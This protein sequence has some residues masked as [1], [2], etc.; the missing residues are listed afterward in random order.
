MTAGLKWAARASDATQMK[1]SVLTHFGGAA[2]ALVLCTVLAGCGKA[3]PRR[4][5]AGS[6]VPVSERDF[7][8]AS[9]THLAS[10]P[11]TFRITNEGPD[12]HE[13]IIAPARTGGLPLRHDGL[14]V[15]EEAI[16]ESEPGSLEPA[17][18]GAVRLLH[19]SLAPGRY[20]FF[21]NMEGHYMGGM[22]EEVTVG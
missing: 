7:H 20:I 18:P 11:V 9:P 14:T 5:D 22:H 6:V 15:A 12:E 2:V 10:G 13:F 3:A 4:A 1:V 21:C 16:E 19:V 17:K 8:I